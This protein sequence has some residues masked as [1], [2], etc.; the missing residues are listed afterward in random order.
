MEQKV[1][2]ERFEHLEICNKNISIELHLIVALQLL[3]QF[4]G[5]IYDKFI[6]THG[7]LKVK[8][9]VEVASRGFFNTPTS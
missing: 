2:N 3:T 4:S 9:K 7:W 1:L 8:V 5:Y 6:E